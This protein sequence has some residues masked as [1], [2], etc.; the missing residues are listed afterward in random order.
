MLVAHICTVDAST[1][2][3]FVE[4]DQLDSPVGALN[5]AVVI[6]PTDRMLGKLDGAVI[7]PAERQVC[8]Y[9]VRSSGWLRTQR[10]LLPATPVELESDRRALRVDVEPEDLTT[11]Q[12]ADPDTVPA[13]SDND[14]VDAMF[15]SRPH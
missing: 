9:V 11:L 15:A 13:F 12:E 14:V 3:R 1:P 4:A 7:N 6:S 8:Y 5:D 2:L 10:Y